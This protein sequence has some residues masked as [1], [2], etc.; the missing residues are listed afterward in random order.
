M[1]SVSRVMLI[2]FTEQGGN[3]PTLTANAGG[4]HM[5]YILIE[6]KEDER[7]LERHSGL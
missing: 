3:S 6:G 4:G 7:D 1:V 5:P 2:L